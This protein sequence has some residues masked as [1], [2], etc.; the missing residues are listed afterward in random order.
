M[1]EVL[2]E[3]EKTS[4]KNI[5]LKICIRINQ[6]QTQIDFLECRRN[7]KYANLCGSYFVIGMIINTWKKIQQKSI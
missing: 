5:P 7:W 3:D 2:L 4:S 6:I 1:F